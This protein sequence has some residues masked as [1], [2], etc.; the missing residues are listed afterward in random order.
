MIS[1]RPVIIM[2]VVHPNGYAI[3]HYGST[4]GNFFGLAVAETGSRHHVGLCGKPL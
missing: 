4:Y 2:V 1:V 3:G